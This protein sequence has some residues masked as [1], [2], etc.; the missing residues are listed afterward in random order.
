MQKRDK[1]NEHIILD[2]L[3]ALFAI[4]II[5]IYL[6][7]FRR[8]T[9]RHKAF[10]HTAWAVYIL[11]LYLVVFSNSIYPLITLFGNIILLA[12]LLFAYGCG[13]IRTA[14]FRSCIYHA[15]RM[16]VEV[17]TQSILLAA[18]GGDPFAA[19]NLISTIAMYIIIQMYKRWQGRDQ[20]TPLPMRHWI[21]LFFIPVFSMIITY[22]TYAITLPNG[23]AAF[24]YF[25]SVLIILINYIIFD[26]YDKISAQ[27]LIERQNQAY[28]QE[29][30]LCVKQA[31]EREE[32]YRQTRI[33]RHDLKGRLVALGALLEAGRIDETK[34]EIEKMLE[35]NSMNRHGTAETGNLALDALVNYK[36]AAAFAEGIQMTCRL[37][38]PSELFV[39][40]P[41][42]CIILEN[43]LGNA[44]EAVRQLP[45]EKEKWIHLTVQLLKGVLLINVE[46]PYSGEVTVD[47]H[48]K[49]R[50]SKAG[51]HG[52]GLLSV[53]RTTKKYAGEVSIRHE[54]GIFRVNVMLCQSDILHENT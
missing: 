45:Q 15:S 14:L 25:L 49:L 10:R 34:K 39:D 35:E 41:D 2:V 32:A 43:L 19:G 52:I 30:S 22:Y 42:L 17:V 29:I 13:D 37:E 6:T 20:T 28:E 44:L 4:Q 27:A 46:N 54:G 11:F 12:A 38:V 5:R 40:G 48:G 31:A 50:S 3:M 16:V 33:L 24:F 26:V 7:S 21:K 36:Y 47:S 1:M 53:E 23:M 18:L 9:I 51:E 8:E